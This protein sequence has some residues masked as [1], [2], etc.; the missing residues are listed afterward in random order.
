[1]TAPVV[2]QTTGGP[3][4]PGACDAVA[5]HTDSAGARR[6]MDAT[7]EIPRLQTAA[8]RFSGWGTRNGFEERAVALRQAV[9]AAGLRPAGPVRYACFNPPWTPWFPPP[10]EVVPPVKA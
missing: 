10:N 7:R 2:Q 4:L 8:V 9:V 6:C 1:M 5:L 3:A